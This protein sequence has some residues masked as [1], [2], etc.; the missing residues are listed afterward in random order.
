MWNDENEWTYNPDNRAYDI[1][2]INRIKSVM[3]APIFE[4]KHSIRGRKKASEITEAVF[5]YME[6]CRHQEIMRDICKEYLG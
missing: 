6:R 1:D 3:L 5:K 4:L 2:S